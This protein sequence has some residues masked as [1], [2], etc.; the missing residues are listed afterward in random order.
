MINDGELMVDQWV[1]IGEWVI[2]DWLV[3]FSEFILI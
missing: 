3:F 1:K 2:N